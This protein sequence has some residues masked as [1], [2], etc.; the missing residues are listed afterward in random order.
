LLLTSTEVTD[1]FKQR[2]LDQFFGRNSIECLQQF[3]KNLE[4]KEVI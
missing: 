1:I 4:V 3:N 2:D